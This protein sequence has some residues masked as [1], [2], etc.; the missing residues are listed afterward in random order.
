M[1]KVELFRWRVPA[2]GKLRPYLSAVH[3][4]R[5]DALQQYGPEA[6]PDL[7]TRRERD[8]PETDA[9]RASMGH[10]QSAGRDGAK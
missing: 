8:V 6:E 10:R 5:E 9:E 3:L 1:K 7:T 4:T 2:R